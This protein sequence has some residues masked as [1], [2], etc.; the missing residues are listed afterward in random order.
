MKKYVLVLCVALALVAIEKATVLNSIE[1][2]SNPTQ[3][4][5]SDPIHPPVG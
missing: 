1:L 4:E 5:V 2:S 3:Q